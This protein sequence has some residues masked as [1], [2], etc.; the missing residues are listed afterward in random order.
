MVIEWVKREE[1]NTKLVIFFSGWSCEIAQFK[2]ILCF[3]GSDTLFIS[4]YREITDFRYSEYSK[5]SDVKVVAWSFGVFIASLIKMPPNWLKIAINGTLLPVN[6]LYGIP[7]KGFELTLKSIIKGGI[8]KFNTRISRGV[9]HYFKSTT[10]DNKSLF[11]ELENL[12]IESK[13]KESINKKWDVAVICTTDLIFP[14]ENQRNFWQE[15]GVKKIIEFNLPHY[16]FIPEFLT[17]LKI[18]LK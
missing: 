2:D 9:E 13:R 10:K 8:T 11:D 15:N 12:Y 1:N 6:N 17:E 16:P 7:E 4:D 5:Y 18:F 14:A 3:D